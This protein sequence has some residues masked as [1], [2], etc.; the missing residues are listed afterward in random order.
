MSFKPNTLFYSDGYK[1]GHKR[2]LAP[3][4][5]KLYGSWIPRS[6]KVTTSNIFAAISNLENGQ[7][8]GG[9]SFEKIM[10]GL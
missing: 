10:E 2:M 8:Y 4:T 1:V 6:I 9:F 7:G 3:G 5:T